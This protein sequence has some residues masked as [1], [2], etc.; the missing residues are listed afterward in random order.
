[1]HKSVKLVYILRLKI[2][3]NQLVQETTILTDKIALVLT[4]IGVFRWIEHPWDL[5][6][7]CLFAALYSCALHSKYSCF[8]FVE[9]SHG[10][11]FNWSERLAILISIAKAVHF[12]HT[13]II[14]GFFHNRLKTNNI[15]LNEHGMAK[16][17][18]YGLSIISEETD[19]CGVGLLIFIDWLALH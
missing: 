18:D 8:I 5:V 7:P 4:N 15:L 9:N 2:F 1:M 16:L 10:K 6:F 3:S 11:V 13:G 12:L 19:K 17:S 14:P